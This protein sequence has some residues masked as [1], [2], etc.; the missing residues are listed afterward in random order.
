MGVNS[1]R[2]LNIRMEEENYSLIP[3]ELKEVIISKNV[4]Y[5]DDF[6]YDEV[7]C[8][9]KKKSDKAYKDL[10]NREYDLKFNIKKQ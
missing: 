9:L 4:T 10:R 7:W 8:E 6:S 5:S 1:K 2:F 3:N